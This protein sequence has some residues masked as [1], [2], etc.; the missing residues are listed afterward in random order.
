[1][2][3]N[4]LYYME[5]DDS[6]VLAKNKHEIYDDKGYF[7]DNI[8]NKVSSI[9]KFF[10]EEVL[11]C[12]EIPKDKYIL[13]FR[14]DS[15]GDSAINF[16]EKNNKLLND[17]KNSKCTLMT[18][19]TEG[20]VEDDI[21]TET[22]ALTENSTWANFCI[23]SGIPYKNITCFGP[24]FHIT[25]YNFDIDIRFFNK[26]GT[27]IS[28]ISNKNSKILFKNSKIFIRPKHFYA[29]GTSARKHRW[30]LITYLYKENLLDSGNISFFSEVLEDDE[31]F[32]AQDS[33]FSNTLID[34]VRKLL[35]LGTDIKN[36]SCENDLPYVSPTYSNNWVRIFN[37]YFYLVTGTLGQE[38]DKDKI[39]KYHWVE[40]KVWKAIISFQPFIFFGSYKALEMLKTF[41]FK[42]FENWI[43]ESYDDELTYEG[44]KKI[45]HKEVKRLC[46]MDIE[47]LDKWYWEMEDILI[48]NYNRLE[49]Y[50]N[51][52]YNKI[53]DIFRQK[54][55]DL[56]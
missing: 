48:Y 31:E 23:G 39:I 36:I 18:F 52:E 17:L 25:D 21:N 55:G 53:F 49:E 47:E 43:D 41:G 51:E 38:D 33:R 13:A 37:S 12:D 9:D 10:E 15:S 4:F 46:S 6:F 1:M 20:A 50:V 27:A 44:R 32:R 42:T 28:T 11:L 8:V 16:L 30:E 26:W 56:L 54:I 19:R 22:M 14:S 24:E 2:K 3:I 29:V 35:P 7:Q 34:E 45:I 5:E 40:E